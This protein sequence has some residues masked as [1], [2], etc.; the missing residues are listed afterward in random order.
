M[1]ENYKISIYLNNYLPKYNRTQ[2]SKNEIMHLPLKDAKKA[3]LSDK[4]TYILRGEST[5]YPYLYELLDHLQGKNF[6]LMTEGTDPGVLIRYKKKIPYISI[7][8][9]GFLN[10]RMRFNSSLTN[11]VIKLLEH[12]KNKDMT[13]RISYTFTKTNLP[14]INVDADILQKFYEL[15]QNVKKPYFIIYQQTEVYNQEVFTWVGIG[16]KT[17]S[18]LSHKGLLSPKNLAFLNAWIHKESY[19]CYSPRGEMVL[20]WDGNFKLCQSMRFGEVIAN[21]SD[22]SIEEII[23]GTEDE[24]ANCVKCAFRENCWLSFHYKDNINFLKNPT[25]LS[26]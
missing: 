5:I 25:L 1:S 2:L 17:I 9:D 12:F 18:M 8:W 11:N 20:S 3:T 22:G 7:N 10:D 26:K 14:W 15:Y 21:I 6:I 16:L 13:V 4:Y 23:E 19:D 24:R